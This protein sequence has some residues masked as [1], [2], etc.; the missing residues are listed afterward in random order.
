MNSFKNIF[1]I[2]NV[3]KKSKKRTT[4]KRSRKNTTK[5]R[6]RFMRGG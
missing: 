4:R 2:F 6:N 1:S 5:K 3:F